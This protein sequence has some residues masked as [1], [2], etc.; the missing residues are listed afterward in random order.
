MEENECIG[1]W[2]LLLSQLPFIYSHMT[3]EHLET[4]AKEMVKAI[5]SGG[6]GGENSD[7]ICQKFSVVDAISVFLGSEGFVEM[8]VLQEL[9]LNEFCVNLSS[10][11]RK[12]YILMSMSFGLYFFHTLQPY[13]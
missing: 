9:I 1:Y 7:R 2:S 4:V 12:R 10:C 13:P 8:R 5:L 3:K 11:L 6:G